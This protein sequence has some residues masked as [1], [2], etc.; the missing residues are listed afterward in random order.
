VVGLG[1]DCAATRAN[2]ENA[3]RSVRALLKNSAAVRGSKLK[4]ATDV[5]GM[6]GHPKPQQKRGRSFSLAGMEIDGGLLAWEVW[7]QREPEW[8]PLAPEWA[9]LA[10]E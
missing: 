6:L 8:A 5:A 9:P 7:H 3:A 2:G 1:A 10:L 4:I